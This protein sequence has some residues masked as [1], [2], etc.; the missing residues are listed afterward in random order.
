MRRRGAG[1]LA[2]S[3]AA[4]A[5]AACIWALGTGGTATAAGLCPNEAFRPSE[6][7]ALAL[8]LDSAGANLPDCRAFEQATPVDKNAGDATATVSYAKASA[9]GG[10][11]SFISNSGIPGAVGAQDFPSYLASRGGAGWSTSGLL[12][13]ATEGQGAELL[14]HTPDFSAVFTK[15]T[16]LGSPSETELLSRP[17]S[18]GPL[19]KVVDYTVG[20]NPYFAGTTGD[21]SLLFESPAKL[22][23]GALP[24]RPNVYLWERASGKVSLAGALNDGSAPSQGAIAG[25]YDWIRGTNS[26]TLSTGGGARDYY[27][28][29]EHAIARDGSAAFFTA[30][31]S[32]TLYERL[33]PGE[34]QSELEGGKCTEPAKACTLE[35]SASKKTGGNGPGGTELGGPRPA[36]FQAASADGNIAYFTSQEELTNEANTGPEP[37]EAPARAFVSRAKIGPSEAEEIEHDCVPARASGLASDST[38][39]YW[40]D[41][42]AG[43]IGRA[44]LDC[45]PASVEAAFIT[46]P[47]L[48]GIE[49][50]AVGAGHIYWTEPANNT[51]GRADIDGNP[52]SVKADFISGALGPR[53]VAAGGGFLYWTN[54]A[55]HSLGRAHEDGSEVDQKFIE[56]KEPAKT[57]PRQGVAVDPAGGHIYVALGNVYIQSYGLDGE[58]DPAP[59]I[60]L[61]SLTGDVDLALD[62]S[63]VYWS[64]EGKTNDYPSQISRAKLDLSE[65]EKPFIEEKEGVEHAQSVAAEA[66]H[67]YWANDPPLSTKPGNDLYRFEAATGALEDL[68]ADAGSEDGAQVQGVLGASEDGSVVYFTANGDLDGAGEATAGDC[69]GKLATASGECSLYRWEE[70]DSEP[71]FV[72]R[73]GVAGDETMSDAANWAATPTGISPNGSFQKT[74]QV[75]DEGEALLFRSQ[76]KL[77]AYDNTPPD[78]ACGTKE[79]IEGEG[80]EKKTIVEPLPCPE[81]YL[82][83]AGA[84]IACVSCNP[85][86]APPVGRPNLGDVFPGTNTIPPSTASIASHNLAAAGQRVFFETPDAL[87]GA[88][89]NGEPDCPLTPGQFAFLTCLD[90][91]EW[92]AA[93]TGG[94]EAKDATADGGCIYLLSTG[95]GKEPALLADASASGEDAYFFTRA[96]LVGQD[97]DEL[98]DVYDARAGGGLAAQNPPLPPPPCE[99]AETCHGPPSVP[100]AEASPTTPGFFGPGNAKPSRKKH[101]AKKHKKHRRAHAKRRAAR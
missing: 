57:V 4:T 60:G 66:G 37:S 49:D 34:E 59:P 47:D 61:S 45:N 96:R 58:K 84:G 27:T 85:S 22:V 8:G 29:D 14:G 12:P 54:E 68:S 72:A 43:A 1:A 73:L 74:A 52:A 10:G 3:G 71:S 101:K 40:A 98:V 42:E 39:I 38:Y 24:G 64:E 9:A 26:A 76:Q 19:I 33:N 23:D 50:L 97:K 11:V 44:T 82:Y 83:R 91:Y 88:D 7:A 80:E 69:A 18:G 30:V 70:G 79:K 21:G 17:G 28:E 16:R 90:V 92:E 77:T 99:S 5:L 56:F 95:K 87:V 15:A 2:G 75:S 100:P 41:R 13:P 53:G 46:D 67:L 63:H 93:G 48:A 89:I 81:L 6:E 25:P 31:G 51:I 36:A 20:L 55:G 86:G 78:G 94:C 65:V 32:G 62:G 35:V